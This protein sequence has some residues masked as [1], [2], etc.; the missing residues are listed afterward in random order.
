MEEAIQFNDASF[1]RHSIQI[2]RHYSPVPLIS[3]D[4]HKVLQILINLL[5][6]AKQALRET[7]DAS[8]QII[9]NIT[10]SGEGRVRLAVSDNGVGIGGKNVAKYCPARLCPPRNTDTA[11]A[12][13]PPRW[14]PRK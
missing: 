11:L 6:N 10:S 7:S 12:C 8:Q 13:M 14:P 2:V 5:R 4:R 9:V 3:V 1:T